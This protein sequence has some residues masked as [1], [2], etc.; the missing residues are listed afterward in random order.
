MTNLRH[1]L[2][3]ILIVLSLFSAFSCKMKEKAD[4]ILYNGKVYTADESFSVVEAF[5]VRDGM[6]EATGTSSDI[7]SRFTADTLVDAAGKCVFPGFIDSHSH[8]Q[9]YALSLRQVNLRETS[10]FEEVLTRMKAAAGNYPGEWL[11]GR[12]WDQ[13]EWKN[14]A[15]P[16][17]EELDRTFPDRPVVLIRVDGHVLLANE[18]AI[19]LTGVA[20][21]KTFLPGE[22]ELKN[23]RM[24]GI[25]RENATDYIRSR[26]PAPSDETRISLLQRAERNCFAAGLTGVADAGMDCDP[27]KFLDSI[28]GQG[29]LKIR[30]NVMLNPT[31]DNISCFLK[32][33]PYRTEHL[34]VRSV[35][36]YSDGS[37]GSRTALMKK[38]YP[39]APGQ[40]GILATSPEQIRKMCSLAKESGYQVCIHAIGDSAVKLIL[41]IY[42]E[43]LIGKNDFRWRIEHAQVVDPEDL[44][45]F[46]KYSIIPSVQATHATSDMD[47]AGDRLGEER[48]KWAYAYKDLLRQNGWIA[49]GTDF[50]IE[51]IEPLHTFYAAVA[52]MNDKGYPPG[53]FQKENALTREEALR[54]ITIWAAKASFEE[55]FRGSLE[56]DKLADFVILDRDIM[57]EAEPE[58]LQTRVV[59]TYLGGKKVY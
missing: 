2:C 11:V 42:S 8:F 4:L 34:N 33:G 17:K 31:A 18:E 48:I 55:R 5:A 45:L 26:I 9:G 28:Q 52:R 1:T 27:V 24:T 7:R 21:V 56:K 43:F 44:P 32:K 53:G 14:K 30:L 40:T 23:G 51:G 16:D 37:L 22:A 13:N 35:K 49:N 38:T 57:T 25:F 3:S 41:E 58:I 29:L 20:H 19:K 39:D 46:G 36:M 47:W 15:F 54:S 10:S 12:G 59:A 6:I 50:P